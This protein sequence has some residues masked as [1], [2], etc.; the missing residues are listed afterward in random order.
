MF[1]SKRVGD[2]VLKSYLQNCYTQGEYAGVNMTYYLLFIIVMKTGE[3]LSSERV[4]SNYLPLFSRTFMPAVR[5]L[6]PD[7]FLSGSP[8]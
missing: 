2:H 5:S 4:I 8:Q 1:S 3:P 6:I 7:L